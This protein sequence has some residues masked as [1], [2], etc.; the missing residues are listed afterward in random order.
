M[1]RAHEPFAGFA[2]QY[3]IADEEEAMQ[4]QNIDRLFHFTFEKS[5]DEIVAAAKKK[6]MELL[7]KVEKRSV[8]IQKMRAEHKVTDAVL[9]DIQ[10]QMRAQQ[11]RG[12]QDR[13]SYTSNAPTTAG[14]PEEEVTIGAGV[15]NFL[16][17][18]QDHMD[19]EKAQVER[20]EMIV[21]NLRDVTAYTASGTP[22]VVKPKLSYEE[23]KYLGF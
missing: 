11:K 15:I 7:D 21:R 3:M 12:E 13:M 6:S 4:V 17:T 2:I 10:H 1:T 14:G 22:I 9:I 19:G 18:E 8:R 20:L 16:L 23:L 5:A